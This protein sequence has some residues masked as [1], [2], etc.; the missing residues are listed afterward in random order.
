MVRILNG[1]MRTLTAPRSGRRATLCLPGG[2]STVWMAS[3][4]LDCIPMLDAQNKAA[5]GGPGAGGD[6][7]KLAEAGRV[8]CYPVGTVVRVVKRTSLWRFV[9]V[10]E[11][12]D[13]G[14]AGWVQA[15]FLATA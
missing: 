10:I 3:T 4:A 13:K 12:E 1:L 11:G 15:E 8:V 2:G 6:L 9:E 5:R 7:C 14:R